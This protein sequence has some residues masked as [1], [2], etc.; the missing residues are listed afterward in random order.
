MILK[1]KEE[2]RKE[3]KPSKRGLT[4]SMRNKNIK[5]GQKYS[6][7][8]DKMTH[9]VHIVPDENGTLTVSR[10]KSGKEYKPLFDIRSKEV[11]ELCSRADYLQVEVS[12]DAII[13]STYKRTKSV[14][15]NI[16]S[17]EEVLG[18]KTGEIILDRAAGAE[19]AQMLFGKPTLAN[20]AYF[21]SLCSSIPNY[22]YRK[23]K[24]EI[25]KVYD[26]ISLFSGAGLLDYAFRDEQF[27]FVYGVDFDKDACETYKYNIGDHIQCADIRSVNADDV[28]DADVCIGGPCCQAYSNANRNNI[29]TAEGE[30]K[31]LLV[32]D[33]IRIVKAKHVKVFVIENVPQMLTKENGKYLDRVI[34]GLPEYKITYTVVT[35]SQVGGYTTRK[36][37]IIIGSRIGKIELPTTEI[38]TVKTVRDALADVDATWFNY[39]DVTTPRPDTA[40]A[41]SF[42]PQGGNWRDIPAEV[43]KFDKNTHSDR[44]RRLAWDEV[45]PTIVNW[46]KIC[47]MP[48]EGNRIL[49]VSEAA[50]LMGLD[51]SFHVLGSSLNSRQQQIGNGVTQAIGRFVKEHV[52]KAL[53]KSQKILA[54]AN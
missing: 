25:K 10:K 1:T 3:I 35:D 40:K 5:I 17:L 15:S 11:R 2:T 48:P 46:R 33:Y 28:P 4:F 50:A 26:V 9:A 20:D 54:F 32:D 27:R 34:N 24:K 41:M 39:N 13:V 38:C 49:N 43:H 14:A 21:A 31:R 12:G 22:V 6:Y 53:N 8:I 7:F 23:K 52:L 42:V 18:E 45:S 19:S 51:K 30:R 44:Y 37:A 29:D 16:V 36:R 47:M